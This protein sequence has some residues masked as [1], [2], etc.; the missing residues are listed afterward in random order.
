MSVNGKI[1]YGMDKGPI[2]MLAD[3]VV[4]GKW[5]NGELK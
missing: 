5:E 3:G 2:P 4:E 1:D